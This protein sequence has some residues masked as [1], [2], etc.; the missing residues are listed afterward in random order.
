L[1]TSAETCETLIR[2]GAA[3]RKKLRMFAMHWAEKQGDWKGGVSHTSPGERELRGSPGE[4]ETT[5]WKWLR[6]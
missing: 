3:Q 1:K 2:A 6:M 5:E 4:K